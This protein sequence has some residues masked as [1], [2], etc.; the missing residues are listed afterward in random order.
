MSCEHVKCVLDLVLRRPRSLRHRGNPKVEWRW[1]KEK[2]GG[3]GGK[4]GRKRGRRHLGSWIKEKGGEG[5]R[6]R[7][8][9]LQEGG[10]GQHQ[11]QADLVP[12]HRK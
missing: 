11:H 4:R 10:D 5:R 2:G 12:A 8:G 1:V 6:R 7:R 3:E 9:Q